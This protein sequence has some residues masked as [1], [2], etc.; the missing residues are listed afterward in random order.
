MTPLVLFAI[1]FLVITVVFVVLV[2]KVDDIFMFWVTLSGII[3]LLL[4]TFSIIQPISLRQASKRQE[5][6]RV[7]IIYQIE[8]YIENKASDPIKLNEWILT[9]NDWVNDINTKKELYGWW[10]WYH[11]FDMTDHTYIDLV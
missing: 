10:S 1:I 8:R 4:T 9:Y 11:N 6:E 7:Q 2:L 5:L 3:W